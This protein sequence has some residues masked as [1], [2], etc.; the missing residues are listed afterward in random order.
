MPNQASPPRGAESLIRTAKVSPPNTPNTQQSTM[1]EGGSESLSAHNSDFG[2]SVHL[3]S[4]RTIVKLTFH[5]SPT[6]QANNIRFS[7]SQCFRVGTRA[8]T[9]T[10]AQ[11]D[12]HHPNVLRLRIHASALQL[13]LQTLLRWLPAPLRSWA[14]AL[15]PEWFLPATS[16]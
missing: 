7:R 16:S 10:A 1:D 4:P 13:A 11:T 9:A 2:H 5:R 8:V 6:N 15:F 3:P 14:N 12:H